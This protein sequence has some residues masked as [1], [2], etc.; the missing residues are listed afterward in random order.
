MQ[1]LY[2][3]PGT[4]TTPGMTAP[5]PWQVANPKRDHSIL[6]PRLREVRLHEAVEK[7]YGESELR[8][9]LRERQQR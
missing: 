5:V 7:L 1:R 4:G 6:N 8:R 2:L 9:K 3:L